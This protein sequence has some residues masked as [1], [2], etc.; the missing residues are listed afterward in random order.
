[1]DLTLQSDIDP[2]DRPVVI[3]VGSIDLASRD[4]FLKFADGALRSSDAKEFVLDLGGITFLDSLG[5]GALVQLDREGGYR[6]RTMVLRNP[7]ERVLRL[8]ETVGLRDLWRVESNA[9]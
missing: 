8:L 7:S 4:S 3:A 2:A 5:L 9:G 6:G 1:M